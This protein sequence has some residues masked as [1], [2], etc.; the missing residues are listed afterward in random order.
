MALCEDVV[1]VDNIASGIAVINCTMFTSVAWASVPAIPK[2][3]EELLSVCNKGCHRL[4]RYLHDRGT[5][6]AVR[7]FGNDQ[8]D[9]S[10]SDPGPAGVH[11]GWVKV[12][13]AR[14][15]NEKFEKLS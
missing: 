12:N 7:C 3:K 14:I 13:L 5:V 1:P 10:S 11:V 15:H 2:R 9:N 6:S 4:G 8:M